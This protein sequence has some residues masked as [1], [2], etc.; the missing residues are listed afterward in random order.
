LNRIEKCVTDRTKPSTVRFKVVKSIT[1][2]EE[3]MSITQLYDKWCRKVEQLW[4]NKRVTQR[5]NLVW[6]IIGILKG[7]SV[8]LSE[9]AATIPSQAQLNSVTKRLERFL[10][11]AKVR[12]REWYKPVI[13]PVIAHL[14][15]TTGV[16]R[17]IIDSSKVG[18]GYQLL[19]VAVA[20]RRRAIPVAW[21]WIRSSKGHSSTQK[22]AALLSY[23]HSLL[24]AD[25]PVLVVGDSEFG[26]IPI[27]Q[28]MEGWQWQYVLRQ[29]GSHLVNQ[30]SEQLDQEECWLAFRTLVTKPGQQVWLPQ[31]HL[32]AAYAH[33][34]NLLA[35]WHK[36]ESEPWLLA[37]NLPTVRCV[38]AAYRRRMWIEEMF[39]DLKGK[40]FELENSRLRHFLR[41]S[42]LTLAV[43][44][45]YLWLLTTGST[46]IKNG[47]R[48]L[49][50]RRN[51]RDLSL[52]RIGL[53]WAQRSMTN[54]LSLNLRL[55][56]V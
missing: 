37:T 43:A 32:T 18:H 26:I 41:L 13:A 6:L 2:K 9:I 17:L 52:F 48:H 33:R 50:D 56:P 30:D 38:L 7:R 14:A 8:E 39:G 23:V 10:G 55:I 27:M 31:V 35:Y 15:S 12:V 53:R 21:T 20:Y 3:S 51:R 19:M 16:I 42:R 40:G 29:K 34:V 28:L 44:L 54:N 46:T 4:P 45:L 5:R 25:V 47:Q 49:V 1:V 24:P 11:N 36:T 22:Q